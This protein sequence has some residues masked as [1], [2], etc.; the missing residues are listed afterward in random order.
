VHH[1][2]S[3][4]LE[5]LS[6]VRTNNAGVRIVEARRQPAARC[7]EKRERRLLTTNPPSDLARSTPSLPSR[8]ASELRQLEAA[9]RK[10]LRG[11]GRWS[12][13]GDL[14]PFSSALLQ[15]RSILVC[16]IAPLQQEHEARLVVQLL[17]GRGH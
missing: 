15:K 13:C 7:G 1:G 5:D 14:R 6:R 17:A 12:H 9:V 3:D 11:F 16:A 10:S 4:G 8:L 2:G